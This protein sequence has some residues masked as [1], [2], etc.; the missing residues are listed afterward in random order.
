MKNRLFGIIA[1]T[2]IGGALVV[3]CNSGD[4]ATQTAPAPEQ[5]AAMVQPANPAPEA[6]VAVVED[7]QPEAVVE[8][9]APPV[10]DEVVPVEARAETETVAPAESAPVEEI[11]AEA[12]PFSATTGLADFSAYRLSFDTSFDGTKNGAPTSGT[13]GGQFDVTTAPQAQHWLINMTGNAFAELALLGGKMEM[14][15]I[16]DTIY[17]QNPGDGSFIGMPAMFVESMLPTDMYNPA[18]N[19]ELP[20]TATL[21]PGEETINGVVAQRYTFGKDDLAGDTSGFDS[22]AG[23][24][25]VA[26][27]GN[28]VVKYEASISGQFSNLTAGDMKVLD[29]GTINMMYEISDANGDFTIAPPA[30]AQAIDLTR[31]LFN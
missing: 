7:V 16:A 22:V 31:L 23:T 28:Y 25:W 6:E 21:Q 20:A 8:T 15:D 29:E 9:A 18:D 10:I 1:T 17:M 12:E 2:V 27:D 26:V 24:V 4:S 13:L 30:G 19:I 3:A 14:Y 5:P 11:A